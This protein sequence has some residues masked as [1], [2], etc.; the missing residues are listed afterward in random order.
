MLNEPD[1]PYN[2]ASGGGAEK[3]V[4]AIA[5]STFGCSGALHPDQ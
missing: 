5:D 2:S 3:R 4:V 1:E